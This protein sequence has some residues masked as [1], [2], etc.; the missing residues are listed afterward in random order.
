MRVGEESNTSPEIMTR[1]LAFLRDAD[2]GGV[3][4]FF[5]DLSRQKGGVFHR[6]MAEAS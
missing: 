3:K 1:C 2:S 5:D 6:F 4:A